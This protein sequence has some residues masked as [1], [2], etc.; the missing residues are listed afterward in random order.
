MPSAI[1]VNLG[2]RVKSPIHRFKAK[3]L[4]F[5]ENFNFFENLDFS[6]ILNFFLK[7]WILKNYQMLKDQDKKIM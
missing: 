6:E 1:D 7:F 2:Y 4:N 5:L 3:I